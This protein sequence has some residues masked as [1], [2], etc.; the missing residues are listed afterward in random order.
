MWGKE[1]IGILLNV[2]GEHL[3]IILGIILYALLA[4]FW[5]R[6]FSY[7]CCM[8]YGVYEYSFISV[9]MGLFWPVT[10]FLALFLGLIRLF[11]G[12]F[13]GFKISG[14]IDRECWK[15]GKRVWFFQKK[16]R[17]KEATPDVAVLSHYGNGKCA[18]VKCG[19]DDIRA[20][21]IDHINGGGYQEMKN[22]SAKQRYKLVLQ[23]KKEKN[24]YQLLCA[25]CN[26]I[27]RFEDK[28]VK[29]SPRKY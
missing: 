13:T 12:I 10:L 21:S 5:I 15:C 25:N 28:E 29:G 1:M 19:F 3:L 17:I 8:T 7:C 6:R 27:K 2:I 26:W 18:C 9:M 11:I 4:I 23:T 16:G 24:K 20:L 22:L 14:Y